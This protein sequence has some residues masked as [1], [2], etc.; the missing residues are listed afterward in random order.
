MDLC[1]VLVYQFDSKAR[2]LTITADQ[3][4][5]HKCRIIPLPASLSARLKAIAPATPTAYLWER[6]TID[7]RAR[8]ARAAMEFTPRRLVYAVRRQFDQFASRFPDRPKMTPHNLRARVITLTV[9]KYNGSVATAGEA[10]GVTPQT[11]TKHYVDANKAHKPLEVL[12]EMASVLL[13]D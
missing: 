13:P 3:S 10:M 9:A 4:K 12:R 6:Y 8:D 2:T 1:Q 11:A 7:T 5:T